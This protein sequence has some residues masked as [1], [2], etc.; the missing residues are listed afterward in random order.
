MVPTLITVGEHLLYT[1][2]CTKYFTFAV[3]FKAY[4]NPTWYL[5]LKKLSNIPFL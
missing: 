2:D 3:L 5:H 1:S 4:T